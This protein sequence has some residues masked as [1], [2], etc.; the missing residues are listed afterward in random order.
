MKKTFYSELSYVIGMLSLAL[1]ASLLTAADLGLS[2][3]I[4][5]AYILH[6]KISEFIPFFSFGMA[7]Y[8][9]QALLIV[10]LTVALRRFKL[11]YLFSFVTAVIYGFLLDLFIFI[12]APLASSLIGVRILIFLVGILF[13]SFGVALLFKT[14]ISPEAYELIVKEISLKFGKKLGYV[15]TAYDLSSLALAVTLSFCFFGFM[16]FKGVYWGTLFTALFNGYIISMLGKLL[17]KL[18]VFKDAFPL[19][20][21][22]EN[23]KTK[24][25]S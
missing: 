3:V 4:A 7:E 15:K 10:I 25:D 9:F 5:P 20:S 22:F 14:Y 16:N 12:T 6:L 18:F 11:S 19:R 8:T 13:S 17:D 21:F 2:M 23:N 1:G 24:K